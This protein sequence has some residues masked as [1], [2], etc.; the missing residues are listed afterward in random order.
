MTIKDVVM[1]ED[2]T[3]RPKGYYESLSKGLVKIKNMSTTHLQNAIRK[4]DNTI[5]YETIDGIMKPQ[6]R[7]CELPIYQELLYE[8]SKRDFTSL[9]HGKYITRS[10]LK[11]LSI[12]S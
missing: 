9:S 5:I 7:G 1:G 12:D 10:Q 8:Y 11:E 4:L 6:K 3:E 2:F